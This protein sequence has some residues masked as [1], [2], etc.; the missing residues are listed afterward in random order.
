MAFLTRNAAVLL[1]LTFALAI[2]APG[3]AQAAQSQW[4]T[5]NYDNFDVLNILD[6]D[7]DEDASG[8]TD[9]NENI[10]REASAKNTSVAGAVILRAINLLTLLVGTF[11][12]VMILIGGIMFV[13]AGG[14]ENR[15]DKAKAILNQAIVGTFLAFLAYFMVVFVQ[16]FFY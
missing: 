15:I 6:V 4:L 16:S 7:E 12:F 5:T 13:T 11:S 9:L 14:E 2:S 10:T 1:G 3:T 8:S